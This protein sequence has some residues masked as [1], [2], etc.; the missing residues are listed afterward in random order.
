MLSHDTRVDAPPDP[1]ASGL[2]AHWMLDESFDFLNHGS[3][4]A[5]PRRIADAQTAW[6]ARIEAR[7]IELLGRRSRELLGIARRSVASLIGAEADDLGFVTN[8][9]EGVN[10]YLSGVELRPGDEIVTTDHVYNAVRQTM[11]HRARVAGATMREVS[12]P[13]PVAGAA[14]IRS[15]VT[16][17]LTDRTRLLVI[18]HVTSPTA[19]VFPIQELA[20]ICAE[21]GID[22]LVDGAHAPGMLPL[23]LAELPG[24]G[25]YAANLHKWICAPK[26]SA[27]L[28][29]R[30]DRQA[31]VHPTVISHFL[32]QGFEAEFSWQGTRDITPWLCAVDAIEFLTGLGLERVMAH[33]HA[34]AR[35]VQRTLCAAWEVEPNS[36]G[37]GSMLGSM[38]TVPLPDALQP[39]RLHGA[40]FAGL[41]PFDPKRQRAAEA[42]MSILNERFRIEVP[43]VDFANRWHVRPCCQVYNTPEQYIRL[44]DAIR[45]LARETGT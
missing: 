13:L 8:A 43:L 20:A 19:L 4:G 34:L 9:T 6:R 38:A 39:E 12:V 31:T 37:D 26:G 29:V 35:W 18:D 10:A 27:F 16:D 32:E 11:R 22:M 40:E 1:I 5:L 7:P 23:D 28:W 42:F 2:S 21:R 33:N 36:P 15:I 17:A 3:F 25:G 44:A 30:R 24:V 41:S 14:S 45:T